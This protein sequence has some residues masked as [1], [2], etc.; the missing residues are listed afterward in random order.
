MEAIRH[1]VG[2]RAPIDEVHDALATNAGVSRWWTNDVRG[3]ERAGDGAFE[4][5]FGA[6]APSATLRRDAT[7]APGQ[8]RWRCTQG[9]DSWL[10]TTVTFDLRPHDGET[11][12]VFTH[13]G[14]REPVEFTHHC[15]TSWACYLI[16]LKRALEGGAA[17]PWPGN[18]RI[19][20]WG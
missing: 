15:S 18:E 17:T 13:D 19:S 5:W 2:I 10:D 4:V 12:V 16:S 11:V 14:W 20:T 3:D 8:V 6:A 7:A 1:R 9:P